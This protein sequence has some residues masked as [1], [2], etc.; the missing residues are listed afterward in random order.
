MSH[1][2]FPPGD[3]TGNAEGEYQHT[4]HELEAA[5]PALSDKSRAPIEATLPAV[6][7]HIEEIAEHFYRHLFTVHPELLDGTF[8]RG[9]EAAGTQQQ[10][11]AGSVPAFA[12]ALVNTPDHLLEDPLTRVAH[13]HP[14]LR[15]PPA[16][17][18]VVHATLL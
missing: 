12:S 1:S 13:K 11:L 4:P 7:E 9:N 6:A 10:A 5:V 14:S 16:H 17:N 2:S 18:Q 15:I 8:N 3:V